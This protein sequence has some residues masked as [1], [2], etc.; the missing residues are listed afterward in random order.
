MP[1]L[2]LLTLT[3]SDGSSREHKLAPGSYVIG[4]EPDCDIVVML[5][6]Q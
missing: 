1:A 3:E 2:F 6:R 4:R 5:S